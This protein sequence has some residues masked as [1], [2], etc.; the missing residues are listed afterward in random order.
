[1][2]HKLRVENFMS[3]KDA[4]IDLEPLTILV[5]ANGS[6]KSA[7]FKA[8]VVLSKLLNGTPI[9]GPKGE[10]FLEPGITLDNLVWHGNAGLPIRFSVWLSKDTQSDPDYSLELRKRAE[11]WSI[12]KERIRTGSGWIEV[13]E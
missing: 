9:R 2:I 8:I 13:D 4:S 10:F 11:G 1:M 7:I 5:G 3:L 12:E 6:G